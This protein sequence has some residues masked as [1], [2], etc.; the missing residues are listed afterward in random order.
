MEKMQ[1]YI[2]SNYELNSELQVYLENYIVY[3]LL[4]ICV[5][6]CYNPNNPNNKMKTLKNVCNVSI[7]KQAV[8]RSNYNSLSLTRKI[9][10]FALKHK[11]YLLMGMIC[12]YRQLQ[13][14]RKVK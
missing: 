1:T 3:H 12:Q 11:L 7:F 9:S 2:T 14:R 6:Y 4:L 13:L 10:L 8:N 5:N